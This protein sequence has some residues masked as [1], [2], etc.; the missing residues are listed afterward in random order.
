G[1]SAPKADERPCA[2]L[3]MTVA[4]TNLPIFQST[5]SVR[6]L[7][8]RAWRFVDGDIAEQILD[9]RQ[10]VTRP[11]LVGVHDL[12]VTERREVRPALPVA[13]HPGDTVIL[14][15]P[16]AEL[17]EASAEAAIRF[18]DVDAH[19]HALFLARVRRGGR[20][21]VKLVGVLEGL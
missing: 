5:N 13:L 7:R 1:A 3:R 11:P 21:D 19:Q 9:R 6:L 12:R 18:L 2:E 4:V 17:A 20:K 14:I 8:L 16:G 15:G 10:Q